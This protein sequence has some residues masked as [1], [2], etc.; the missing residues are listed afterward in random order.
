MIDY[1]GTVTN[2]DNSF[3]NE[4]RSDFTTSESG[5]IYHLHRFR[6][7]GLSYDLVDYLNE[8]FRGTYRFVLFNLTRSLLDKM[9]SNGC[10]GIVPWTC[11]AWHGDPDETIFQ[12][13]PGFFNDTNS[14]ISPAK[15]AL[16]IRRSKIN[17]GSYHGRPI[18]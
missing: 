8:K 9:L 11:A 3:V 14:I 18:S 13:T 2:L 12:W 17:G 16:R 6:A 10:K 1:L 15:I 5:T 7:K 4:T